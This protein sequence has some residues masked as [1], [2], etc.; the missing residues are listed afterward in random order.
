MDQ[1]GF[2]ALLTEADTTNTVRFRDREAAHLPGDR[3]S[4]IPFFR[5]LLEDHHAAMMA[6]DVERVTALREEARLLA[7]KLNGHQPG[8]WAG[9]DAPGCVLPRETRAAEGQIPLGGQQGAFEITLAG[10]RIRAEM[11]SLLGI[12]S[13]SYWLRFGFDAVDWDKLFISE[14]G[15]RSFL[16]CAIEITP[17]ITPD[18]FCTRVIEQFVVREMSGRL[19]NIVKFAR[20]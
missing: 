8:I 2:D 7:Q 1:L 16:G 17:G 5:A 4:A 18:A 19:V 14:T 10:T 11:E 3:Q 6:A 13:H 12:T 9:P 20:A 15:Y